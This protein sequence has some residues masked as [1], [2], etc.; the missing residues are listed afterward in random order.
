MGTCFSGEDNRPRSSGQSNRHPGSKSG[1]RGRRRTQR[2]SDRPQRS[3][4]SSHRQRE[5]HSPPVYEEHEL[6]EYGQRNDGGHRIRVDLDELIRPHPRESE[7]SGIAYVEP[8]SM[9]LPVLK[10]PYHVV[11]RQLTSNSRTNEGGST[12]SR[13]TY[14]RDFALG[15]LQAGGS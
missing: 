4:T 5:D 14:S 1:N 9:Y 15:E 11:V 10:A 3:G 7:S 2:S 13:T 12:S 6:P 8:S